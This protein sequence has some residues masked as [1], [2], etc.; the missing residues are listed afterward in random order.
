MMIDMIRLGMGSGWSG[1]STFVCI[2][3]YLIKTVTCD[4]IEISSRSGVRW[5]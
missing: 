1:L 3:T 5:W 2:M 4:D